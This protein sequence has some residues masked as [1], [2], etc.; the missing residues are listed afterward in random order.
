MRDDPPGRGGTRPSHRRSRGRLKP[1]IRRQLL[2]ADEV[3]HL[4]QSATAGLGLTAG[5]ELD[6]RNV[7][8]SVTGSPDG[9]YVGRD[10]V[11]IV[12]GLVGLSRSRRPRF[13]L[14]TREGWLVLAHDPLGAADSLSAL[15]VQF[16]RAA[17]AR[18][19]AVILA[20]IDAELSQPVHLSLEQIAARWCLSPRTLYLWRRQAM[21]GHQSSKSGGS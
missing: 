20:D 14:E 6:V 15:V 21:R 2:R 16:R 18:R 17:N 4:W 12:D 19:K 9:P 5:S 7:A 8:F 3:L 13:V 1:T 11:R 10:V